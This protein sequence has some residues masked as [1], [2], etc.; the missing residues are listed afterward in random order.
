MLFRCFTFT[1][2][3]S[4]HKHIHIHTYQTHLKFLYHI[5]HILLHNILFSASYLYYF[6]KPLWF[7]IPYKI[8][9]ETEQ[10][11][12]YQY[13]IPFRSIKKW[14]ILTTL[15]PSYNMDKK[16]SPNCFCSKKLVW[17]F[18][19]FPLR[20]VFYNLFIFLWIYARCWTYIN[21][22]CTLH[23]CTCFIGFWKLVQHFQV[24]IQVGFNY[25]LFW[26]FLDLHSKWRKTMKLTN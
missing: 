16:W 22:H 19:C 20:I 26:F 18:L 4:Y 3:F 11:V 10:I 23:P 17:I 9:S 12:I 6:I 24:N 1:I 2:N 13:N 25:L 5:N 21:L 14:S 7:K 15:T 8:G